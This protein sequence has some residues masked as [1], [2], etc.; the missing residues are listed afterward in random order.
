[1]ESFLPENRVEEDDACWEGPDR[2]LPFACAS[3]LELMFTTAFH[4]CVT[5]L[6]SLLSPLSENVYHLNVRPK[7]TCK[8]HMLSR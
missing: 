4:M 1:M 5:A 3:D 8:V 6:H 7:Q 2:Q